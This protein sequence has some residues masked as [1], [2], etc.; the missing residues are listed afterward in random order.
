[1]LQI[2]I[3]RRI[4]PRISYRFKDPKAAPAMLLSG[5]IIVLAIG[6][7]V[8]TTWTGHVGAKATYGAQAQHSLIGTGNG[9]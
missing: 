3:E 8:V 7:G 4:L 1:L 6:A 9:P 5:L 2:L